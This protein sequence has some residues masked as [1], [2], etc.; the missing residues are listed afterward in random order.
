MN[1]IDFKNKAENDIKNCLYCM[2]SQA[3]TLE[4]ANDIFQVAR[5]L[6]EELRADFMSS[7][8]VEQAEKKE[9][10]YNVRLFY[11]SAEALRNA[12]RGISNASLELF[13]FTLEEYYNMEEA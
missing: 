9:S 2:K 8:S 7:P 5:N 4:L 11:L 13:G 1:T 10:L 6:I 3:M 12:M